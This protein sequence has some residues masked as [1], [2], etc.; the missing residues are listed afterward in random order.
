MGKSMFIDKIHNQKLRH[1]SH[2]N[3]ISNTSFKRNQAKNVKH[4]RN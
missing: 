1:Y 2:E 4:L 3:C